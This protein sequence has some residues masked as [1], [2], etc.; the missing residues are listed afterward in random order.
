M[1]SA[2]FPEILDQ[3]GDVGGREIVDRHPDEVCL[4]PVDDPRVIVDIDS[5]EDYEAAL[6]LE[7]GPATRARE[8][9]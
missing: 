9:I 3:L 1:G 6:L 5:G 2:L 4:A 8:N 7:G